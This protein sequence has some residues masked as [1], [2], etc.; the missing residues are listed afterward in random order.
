M[1]RSC[2]VLFLCTGNTC[3]SPVAAAL[4][5]ALCAV[6]GLGAV[7]AASAGLAAGAGDAASANMQRVAAELGLS[8]AEHRAQNLTAAL[9]AQS[10]LL[11]CL[12]AS[13]ARALA[14]CAAPERLRILG[15]GIAD[16]YGGSLEDYRA[17]A[18]QIQRA[19][20]LLLAEL[21]APFTCLEPDCSILP[22]TEAHA[23]A[24]AELERR[25]FHPPMSEARLLEKLRTVPT[26]HWRTA[27][28]H[29]ETVGC[30]GVDQYD[31]EAFIDDVA[32]CPEHQRR[33]IGNALLAHAETEAILRGA[34]KIHLEVRESNRA[35]RALYA[36]RGYR[37]VGRRRGFYATP[38]EDAILMTMEVR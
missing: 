32:V 3:R 12:S 4:F 28:W 36:A 21:T 35:A 15:G 25:V 31:D 18:A 6:R 7:E 37:E 22:T 8:L 26:A 33:G 23:P 14:P 24:I 30:I 5:R 34:G 13:H 17:C 29:G 10:D 27:C 20:P 16:P 38:K 19:L 9:L 2:R 11:V 1:N